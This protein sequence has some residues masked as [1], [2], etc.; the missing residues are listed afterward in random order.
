[1]IRQYE[2]ININVAQPVQASRFV[3]IGVCCIDALPDLML[4]WSV[5]PNS[6]TRARRD[7]GQCGVIPQLL[8]RARI[9]V[10]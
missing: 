9:V 6:M 10:V 7:Q 4:G 3:A 8:Q 5:C 1:M 2:L